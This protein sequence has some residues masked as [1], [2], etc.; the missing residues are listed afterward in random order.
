[1]P[2]DLAKENDD[3]FFYFS[4]ILSDLHGRKGER[5]NVGHKF[6]FVIPPAD[7]TERP[8]SPDLADFEFEVTARPQ[9]A[10]YRFPSPEGRF[11]LAADLKAATS[12]DV[13]KPSTKHDVIEMPREDFLRYGR[14]CLLGARPNPEALKRDKIF[15]VRYDAG[16]KRLLER[17][18][19]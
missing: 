13:T 4:N 15:L 12:V 3:M 1:M 19:H 8:A 18:H 9:P 10:F 17:A 6:D 2:I 11:L 5:W 7:D 14:C 16:V